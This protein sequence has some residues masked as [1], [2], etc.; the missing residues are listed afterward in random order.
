MAAARSR[1]FGRHQRE[2]QTAVGGEAL[3]RREVVDVEVLRG[4]GQPAG[5]GRGVED[6]QRIA[7]ALGTHRVDGDPG[8]GLVVRA[9]VDIQPRGRLEGAG[10]PGSNVRMSC[11]PGGAICAAFANFEPNSPNDGNC[12]RSSIRPNV[13]MSQN[14]VEPPLPRITS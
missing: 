2:P 1:A 9:G 6:H 3:L 13:A 7:G 8:R 10:S 12:P 5:R 14:A 4:H 11:S